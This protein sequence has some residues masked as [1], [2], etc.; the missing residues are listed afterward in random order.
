M[1]LSDF[2]ILSAQVLIASQKYI[3][4]VGNAEAPL[5]ADGLLFLL[6]IWQKGIVYAVEAAV[7]HW[8]CSGRLANP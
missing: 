4:L 3:S 2:F 1:L 5:M 6:A 7:T 8:M